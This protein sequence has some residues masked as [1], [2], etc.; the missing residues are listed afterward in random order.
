MFIIGYY[1]LF[2]LKETNII[3]IE[4]GKKTQPKKFNN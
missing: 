3:E 4:K 2:H 1:F